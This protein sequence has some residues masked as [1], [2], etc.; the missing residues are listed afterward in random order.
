LEEVLELR[1]M[2]MSPQDVLVNLRVRFNPDLT[3]RD[4]IFAV[5]RAR[6]QLRHKHPELKHIFIEPGRS[7]DVA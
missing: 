6:D 2:Q 5:D 7:R 4:L 3:V 1:M